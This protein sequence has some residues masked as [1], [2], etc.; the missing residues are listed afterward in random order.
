MTSTTA[1][2]TSQ[3]AIFSRRLCRERSWNGVTV[4]TVWWNTLTERGYRVGRTGERTR[5]VEMVQRPSRAG[6]RDGLH[7][8]AA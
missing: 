2:P 3:S 1:M 4:L 7:G 5:A 6:A 8:C